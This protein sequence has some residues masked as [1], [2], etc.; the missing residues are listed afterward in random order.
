MLEAQ[1]ICKTFHDRWGYKSF[2]A[3]DH[4][5]LKVEKGETLGLMG[6]SGCGKS[7]LAR[8]LLRLIYEDSGR[9][10]FGEEDIS[11]LRGRK[12]RPFRQR[13][14]LIS[15]RPES[16]FDPSMKLGESVI[17][18]LK[19]FHIYEKESAAR[20]LSEAL[21]Q[22][23][24]ND[25]LLERYPHQVSGGEIQR[26]SI[27]RALLLNPEVLVLDEA[28]SMLD[29]SVQAQILHILKELQRL[30]K[31]SYLF[32]SHDR[33]VVEWMCDRV[34]QMEQGKITTCE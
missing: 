34:A 28:T 14:Q 4:V 25:S 32:I 2:S 12:L 3:L 15:Q 26:L 29:V 24:L 9:V 21:E 23:K 1:N 6:P 27:C 30:K 33:A 16:F 11:S 7:T 18:P 22:V 10:L 19:I 5:S 8:I 17:E 31:L 13:V 20:M